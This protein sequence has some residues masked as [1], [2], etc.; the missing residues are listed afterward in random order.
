[1]EGKAKVTWRIRGASQA[2]AVWLAALLAPMFLQ[3]CDATRRDWRT[4]FTTTVCDHGYTC[5][6]DHQCVRAVDAGG[7]DGQAPADLAQPAADGP[8]AVVLD[9]AAGDASMIDAARGEALP[10]FVLD[11]ALDEGIDAVPGAAIDAGI[12]NVEDASVDLAIDTRVPDAPGSCSSDGDCMGQAPYCVDGRCVACKT[13]EECQSGTPICSAGHACISCAAVDSG[14]PSSAPACEV[15]SGR[16]VECASNDDCQ[17]ATKPI[18]DGTSNTCVACTSDAQCAAAGPGVCMSHLDGHCAKDSETVYVG[19]AGPNPCSETATDAGSASVPFCTAEKG[20]RTAQAKGKPLVVLS[21]ALIG[22]FTAIALTAPLTVVGKSA[23][24]VP[25]DLSDGIG[26][27]SGVLYLRGLTV[28]GSAARAT[29][30]GINAQATVGATLDI[31]V[32]DCAVTGNP[33]GGI[34]LAGAAFDI[35]NTTVADNGP[36]QT[37]GGVSF[38]GIRVDSLVPTA[39]ANLDFVTIENNLAPGLSCAGVIQ[40][41]GVL[42]TGNALLNIATSCAITSCT[43][44]S[45]T[46]G[47]QP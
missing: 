18:C 19:S 7:L 22:G 41:Q 40:G 5:T 43:A 29:G 27:T 12:D 26:V 2:L 10:P 47:A 24:I 35:R 8:A 34:M 23:T 17:L 3:G 31:H 39:S 38:G 32:D 9:V 33:G 37:S 11:A 45:P 42:A 16:C 28:A 36:G 30:I 14:C 20:V 4:C 25:G 15:D 6:K 44:P 46:C 13:S 1:M 21:G